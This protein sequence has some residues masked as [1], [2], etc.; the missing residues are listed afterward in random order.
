MKKAI[1]RIY[2]ILCI[3]TKWITLEYEKKNNQ[4]RIEQEKIQDSRKKQKIYY[5]MKILQNELYQGFQYSNFGQIISIRAPSNIR[6]VDYEEKN[7][8][9]IFIYEIDKKNSDQ[10]P[11]GSF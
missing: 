10:I 8:I 2:E 7:N 6:I 1:Q 3:I 5:V 9:T 11:Y 4:Y